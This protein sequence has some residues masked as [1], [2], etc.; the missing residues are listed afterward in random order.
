M[1]EPRE[2]AHG[3]PQRSFLGPALFNMYI[4]DLPSVPRLCSLTS[5]VDDSQ[6]YFSFRVQETK[7][8]KMNL[9]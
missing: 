1:S 7:A 9:I 2:V 4:R 8:A 6:L 5:Y 3:L